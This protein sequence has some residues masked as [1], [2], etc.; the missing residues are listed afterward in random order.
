[1]ERLGPKT[2]SLLFLALLVAPLAHAYDNTHFYRAPYFWGEPRFEREKL[3]SANAYLG[4][5][6]AKTGRDSRGKRVSILDIYGPYNMHK[7][8]C[9]VPGLDPKNELDEILINLC[10]VEDVSDLFGNLSFTGSFHDFEFI[11]EYY[12]NIYNG[13]FL[14]LFLPLRKLKITDIR[15]TDLTPKSEEDI[16]QWQDF[17]DNF[18]AILNRHDLSIAPFN[19]TGLGDFS[20]T[21]GWARNYEDTETLD[22]IDID[23]R[24]GILFPTGKQKDENKVFSLPQGYNGHYAVPLIFNSSLGLWDWFTAGFHI[25]ALFLVDRTRTI[26]LKTDKEQSGFIRIAEGK[27][28]V[29]PGS[30]LN[31]ELFT[32]A[33]HIYHG[34]SIYLVYHFNFRERTCIIPKDTE[35]F[36]KRIVNCDKVFDDWYMNS[37]QFGL[38][39]DCSKK[40]SD[41]GP[42]IGVFYNHVISGKRIFNADLK[43]SY[44]GFDAAWCF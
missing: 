3:S 26:R 36:N 40:L 7:S 17:K 35:A 30:Y 15:F 19:R 37:F 43:Y 41:I 39:Y 38:E 42:R 14:H 12:Q 31:V 27:A 8:G 4:W 22:F 11:T 44:L 24:I 33:D 6:R 9:G 29:D 21:G 18:Q 5:A 23:A 2:H 34:L 25:S 20:I 1:M 16:P 13:F 32:K 10:A 28:E